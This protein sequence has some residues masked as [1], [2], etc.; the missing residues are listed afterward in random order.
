M[1][2]IY[3][4]SQN[5]SNSYPPNDPHD[6]KMLFALALILTVASL[7]IQGVANCSDIILLITTIYKAFSKN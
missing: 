5:Q 2:I 6:E 3:P 4:M 1:D 7:K